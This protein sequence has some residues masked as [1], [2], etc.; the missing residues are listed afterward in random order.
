MNTAEPE[1]ER[2]ESARTRNGLARNNKT[3]KNIAMDSQKGTAMD[4]HGLAFKTRSSQWGLAIDSRK[5]TRTWKDYRWASNGQSIIEL[6]THC[7]RL[8]LRLRAGLNV[9]VNVFGWGL[10]SLGVHV[11]VCVQHLGTGKPHIGNNNWSIYSV[12]VLAIHWL[13]KPLINLY[14]LI[15]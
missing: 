6:N 4:L 10:A 3:C 2:Q 15:I 7:L 12:K 1:V 8:R 9:Y 13:C 14:L 11:N 5:R